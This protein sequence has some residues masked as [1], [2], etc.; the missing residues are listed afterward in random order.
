MKADQLVPFGMRHWKRRR[1]LLAAIST[2]GQGWSIPRG[3]T[4][5]VHADANHFTGMQVKAKCAKADQRDPFTN[6]QLAR[7]IEQLTEN[8]MGLVKTDAAK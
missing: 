7:L 3:P 1:A 5:L 6:A 2:P 8:P 4:G